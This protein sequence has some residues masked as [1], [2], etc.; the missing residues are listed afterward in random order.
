MKSARARF[1]SMPPAVQMVGWAGRRALRMLS[2]WPRFLADAGRYRSLPGAEPLRVRDLYPSLRDRLPS[3][4]YDPHYFFQDTWAARRIAERRPARHVDV[5]SRVDL[6]AFLTA[7]TDMVFVDI[8]PLEARLEGLTI[9]RGSLLDL[10]FAD[11]SVHS[12]SCL[13]VAEHVGLGRY[14]DAL[15]PSGTRKAA[16]ELQ[17]ALAPGGELLF[18]VPVGRPRLCFN[19]HRIHTP[20]DVIA[21]FPEL[22]LVEF[23]AVTDTDELVLDIPPAV[24]ADARYACG[25]FRF[26]RPSSAA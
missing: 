23:A 24:V 6:V 3:S 26:R 16:A 10:P 25:L 4:P 15:D 5:G 22:E 20:E 1:R 17:R 13:H 7:I 2:G 14:G 12:L 9:V 19:A 8:R 18:S 11:A 21:M